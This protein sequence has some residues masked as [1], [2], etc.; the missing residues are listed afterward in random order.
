MR[1]TDSPARKI[2]MLIAWLIGVGVSGFGIFYFSAY[3]TDQAKEV[4]KKNNQTERRVKRTPID[5]RR[6]RAAALAKQR[7]NTSPKMVTATFALG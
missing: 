1:Y 7:K 6:T 4:E 2:I 3:S 5:P